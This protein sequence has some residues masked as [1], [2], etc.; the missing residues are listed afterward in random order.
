VIYM[1]DTGEY[2]A[3]RLVG[4]VVMV[5]RRPVYVERIDYNKTVHGLTFDKKRHTIR[6]K[7]SELSVLSLDLGFYNYNGSAY[8]MSRKALR[9]DWRQGLRP[10]NVMSIPIMNDIRHI[11]IAKCMLH[12]YPTFAQAVARVSNNDYSCAWSKDFCV[13][14]RNVIRWKLYEVGTIGGEKIVLNGNFKFLN[15]LL[16]EQTHECYEII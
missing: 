2:A 1:Y 13:T 11:D 8:Y 15:K 12:R 6:C 5:K 9:H 10:N 4:T 16:R 7:L 3:S 14:N